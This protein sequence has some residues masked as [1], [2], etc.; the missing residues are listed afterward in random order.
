MTDK[1]ART[2]EGTERGLTNQQGE[3]PVASSPGASGGFFGRVSAL[4]RPSGGTS[5]SQTLPPGAVGSPMAKPAATQ[6]VPAGTTGNST[7]ASAAPRT[8]ITSH[9]LGSTELL[10]ELD[11][12]VDSYRRGRIHKHRAL[13]S[14]F[15]ALS[16]ISGA[17]L[18]DKDIA[19][20]RW[21][22][23]VDRVENILADASAKGSILAGA[24]AKGAAPDVASPLVLP[25][26]VVPQKRQRESKIGRAHV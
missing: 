5:D 18:E 17:T 7:S 26:S 22:K 1:F 4:T 6:T 23:E 10:K 9:R 2:N 12:F 16:N 24:S 14:I 8:T 13:F 19:L 25:T 15:A 21:G 3:A 11:G 20:D